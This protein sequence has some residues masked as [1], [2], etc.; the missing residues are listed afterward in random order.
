MKQL[1]LPFVYPTL[2]QPVQLKLRFSKRKPPRTPRECATC[3]AVGRW[4]NL[5]CGP[6]R[7]AVK[8]AEARAA[9]PERFREYSRRWRAA[10]PERTLEHRR[11]WR[12]RERKTQ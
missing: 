6:C 1:Q 11:R 3:G 12:E 2:P 10:N 7:S 4:R 5:D 8:Q 9:D